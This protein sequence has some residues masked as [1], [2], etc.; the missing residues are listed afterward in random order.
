MCFRR[1]FRTDWLWI[2]ITIV[3]IISAVVSLFWVATIPGGYEP[4]NY[5]DMLP[6]ALSGAALTAFFLNFNISRTRKKYVAI[7]PL[8]LLTVI[9]AIII[10]MILGA[11]WEGIE[12]F[13]PWL[14]F[15]AHD[16]W[17]IIRDL[18]A[19]L[20]GAIFTA[21]VYFYHFEALEDIEQPKAKPA[22]VQGSSQ[23]PGSDAM[24]YCDNCGAVLP[25]G[26]HT[27]DHCGARG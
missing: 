24:R 20:I 3:L 6:H 4:Y 14:G 22:Q 1:I 19:D 8:I 9:P 2:L 25:P 5:W 13:M 7:V 18:I 12:V 26:E 16:I 11:L 23:P 27:C 17:N 10:T 21:I 15:F